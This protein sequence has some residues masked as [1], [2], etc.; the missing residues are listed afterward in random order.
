MKED[1]TAQRPVGEGEATLNP[2]MFKQTFN[3]H[4]HF[5]PLCF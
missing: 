1:Q 4:A 2:E 3:K 5:I